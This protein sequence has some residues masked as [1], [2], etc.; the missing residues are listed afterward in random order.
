MLH[1]RGKATGEQAGEQSPR[2]NRDLAFGTLVESG[3]FWNP[4]V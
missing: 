2:P 3:G 1:H 4:Y